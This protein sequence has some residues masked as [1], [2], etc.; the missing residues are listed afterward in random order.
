MRGENGNRVY[1]PAVMAIL[2]Y[3]LCEP[4]LPFIHRPD[5]RPDIRGLFVLR[6]DSLLRSAFN[7]SQTA[8]IDWDRKTESVDL[9]SVMVP[10]DIV[11]SRRL[12]IY[13]F[14]APRC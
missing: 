4:F 9:G 2:G 3:A 6:Y 7:P 1:P 8:S 14:C 10:G 12:P 11:S 5:C 13:L